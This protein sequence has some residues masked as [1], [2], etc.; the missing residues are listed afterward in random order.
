MFDREAIFNTLRIEREK[1][2]FELEE[3]KLKIEELVKQYPN[4]M[5]LGREIRKFINTNK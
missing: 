1:E 2:I 5:E 4:D 3:F